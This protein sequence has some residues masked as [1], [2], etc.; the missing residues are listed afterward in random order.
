[1]YNPKDIFYIK[2]EEY[3]LSR[4]LFLYNL[5]NSANLSIINKFTDYA[6]SSEGQKIVEE[7]GFINLEIAVQSQDSKIK[8]LG[9]L[10]L[11][12]SGRM[13]NSLARDYLDVIRTAKRLSVTFRFR[14]NSDELDSRAIR[15]IERLK[16]FLNQQEYKNSEVMLLGFTDDVGG[17]DSP[18][19]KEL[20]LNRANAIKT[21]LKSAYSVITKGYAALIPVACD[22]EEGR[23]KNRRVEVW[24]RQR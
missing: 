15:D 9:E 8:R 3:P 16:S 7:T 10:Q 19:N 14:F 2:F 5:P 21:K 22:D 13:Q 6:L 24:I 4:R 12:Y 20:A 11:H 17:L 18:K 23:Q 1:M